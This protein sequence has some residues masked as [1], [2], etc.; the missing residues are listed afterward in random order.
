MT[1][2]T[3]VFHTPEHGFDFVPDAHDAEL[4]HV[5]SEYKDALEE[6]LATLE[7]AGVADKDDEDQLSILQWFD[8]LKIEETGDDMLPYS[9]TVTKSDLALYLQFEVLNYL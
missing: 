4:V 9:V 8:A 7:L 1:T 6:F 2:S 3:Y 5:K